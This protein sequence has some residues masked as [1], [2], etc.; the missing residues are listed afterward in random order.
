MN[1]D[2]SEK[3]RNELLKHVISIDIIKDEFCPHHNKSV[4]INNET[5][6]TCEILRKSNVD[7]IYS[8]RHFNQVYTDYWLNRF[9]DWNVLRDLLKLMCYD[10]FICTC[11]VPFDSVSKYNKVDSVRVINNRIGKC[12]CHGQLLK[13]LLCHTLSDGGYF[14]VLCNKIFNDSSL[15]ILTKFIKSFESG[16]LS[17]DGTNNDANC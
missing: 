3:V 15:E 6:S 2:N 11:R 10:T 7:K 14:I 16:A 9:H 1:L 17:S 8:N 4:D 5:Y 12:E 13:L